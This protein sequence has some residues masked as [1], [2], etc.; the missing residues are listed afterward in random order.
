MNNKQD[1]TVGGSAILKEAFVK[2]LESEGFKRYIGKTTHIS[3]FLFIQATNCRDYH[4]SGNNCECNIHYNLPEQWNEALQAFRDYLKED[5]VKV[6]DWVIVNNYLDIFDNIPLKVNR[7]SGGKYFYF[8]NNINPNY[9]FSKI[10][11]KRKA[12]EEEVCNYLAKKAGLK[13]EEYIPNGRY[14]QLLRNERIGNYYSEDYSK[15]TG[16]SFYLNVPCLQVNDYFYLPIQQFID[17][18]IKKEKIF[19]LSSEEITFKLK[20]NKEGIFCGDE[21]VNDDLKEIFTYYNSL[22]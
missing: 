10:D 13:I 2:Q 18:S 12:T 15:I 9:N 11:I 6:G 8:D 7:I 14:N 16:T 3:E 20:V 19:I 1:F 21:R 4:F 22:Q 17:N 5:E